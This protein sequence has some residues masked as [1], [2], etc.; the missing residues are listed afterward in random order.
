MREFSQR[1]G[2]G[3]DYW[4]VAEWVGLGTPGDWRSTNAR[5]EGVGALSGG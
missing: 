2:Y 4:D 1:Y 5:I 3:E